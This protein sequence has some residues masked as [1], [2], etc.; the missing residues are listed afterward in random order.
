VSPTADIREGDQ[1]VSSGL[2]GR[3]PAGYPIGSVLNI[4]HKAGA[5]FIEVD[6][7]PAAKIDR[8]KHLLLVFTSEDGSEIGR[9][10]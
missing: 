2:G 4:E 1:L 7:A 10:Q 5:S 9:S 3:F 8:S 6:V